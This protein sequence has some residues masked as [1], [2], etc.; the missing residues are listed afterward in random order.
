MS[1]A[2]DEQYSDQETGGRDAAQ[3]PGEGDSNP[4]D[5]AADSGSSEGGDKSVEE[6]REAV[7]EN[8][9]FENFG[10]ADMA[11]MSA[12]EWEAA[13]DPD[14][15]ITGAALI[16]RVEADLRT[17]V[18][19]REVFARIER[20]DDPPRLLAYSDSS[21]AMVYPDGSVDG[22]GTVVRD[23]KPTVALCS[24]DS[25]DVPDSPDGPLLPRP[26]EVPESGTELGNNM[27]QV[28][29][30]IQVLAGL[31]LLGGT[32]FTFGSREA[33]TLL[34]AIAGLG[35][36]TIGIILFVVVANARLS[37]SFRAEEYRER[38]RGIGLEDGQRPE[39]LPPAPEDEGPSDGAEKNRSERA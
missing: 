13:F 16:D 24:M 26:D 10:P 19:S 37:D 4:T 34:L 2:E 5:T 8:Y 28:I 32:L 18:Q 21:Y 7:D 39:F 11:D 33:N 15:W 9:D 6:L 36:L 23:V 31:V 14:T 38:L 30:G 27:L 20:Y 29:A 25:Y 22:E 3:D 35:F 1:D 12:E 17:R